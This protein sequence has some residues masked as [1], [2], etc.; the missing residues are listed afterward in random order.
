MYESGIDV[1]VTNYRTPDDLK[2]FVDSYLFQE[3][4]VDSELIIVDVDPTEQGYEDVCNMLSKYDFEF[5]YWPVMHNCGYS[6]ACNFASNTS[7]KEVIAFF[8]ADTKLYSDTLDVCYEYLL[9]H[10]DVAICGPL[11]V[12]SRGLV[13]HAG[14]FG[15]NKH[16]K[17]RGW[18]SQN[19]E[20]FRDV[21]DDAVSV[22]GSAY[23]IKRDVWDELA[24]DP[25]YLDLY[26][27]V[28]G[29][30]LPTPHY[31]EETWCSYFARHKG[32]KVAYVGSAMMVHEWHQSSPVGSVE[33]SLMP[34]SRAMFRQ[35]CSHIGIE[36]D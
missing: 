35:A 30:F 12:N 34:K 17:I 14:I 20:R 32:W 23:F 25:E 2:G 21:C 1:V 27:N 26:P 15:T 10:Q 29:A 36:C 24:N 7:N 31:Y 5:Q 9:A 22:S 19:P 11:Q 6:G 33:S 3:S 4:K 13:K 16:P 8:N 18:N 28:D